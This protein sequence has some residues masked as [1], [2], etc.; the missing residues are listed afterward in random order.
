VSSLQFT[1]PKNHCSA[2]DYESSDGYGVLIDGTIPVID[3]LVRGAV[4][5]WVWHLTTTIRRVRVFSDIS[6]KNPFDRPVRVRS[7]N[8]RR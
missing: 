4:L 6:F 8:E 7:Q 3:G 2:I 1:G 5:Q